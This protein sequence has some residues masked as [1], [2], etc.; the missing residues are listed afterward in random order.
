MRRE[1]C[2]HND[3]QTPDINCVIV[4]AFVLGQ[5]FWSDVVWSS[6]K[7]SASSSLHFLASHKQGSQTEVANFDI[8]IL[9]QKYVP[10]F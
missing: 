2:I 5:Y 1:S 7:S 8:H 6:A 10:H 9:V 4:T 3:T